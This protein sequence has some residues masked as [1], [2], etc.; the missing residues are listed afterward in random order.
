MYVWKLEQYEG[1]K[2]RSYSSQTFTRLYTHFP[3]RKKRAFFIQFQIEPLLREADHE[4]PRKTFRI[5]YPIAHLYCF[6]QLALI[7]ELVK[8]GVLLNLFSVTAI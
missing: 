6:K 1:C 4:L 3:K 8:T 7:Y 5:W 2:L